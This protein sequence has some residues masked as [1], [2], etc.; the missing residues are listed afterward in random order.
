MF[1]STI[2]WEAL[3]NTYAPSVIR[4][5]LTLDWIDGFGLVQPS[6]HFRPKSFRADVTEPELVQHALDAEAQNCMEEVPYNEVSSCANMFAVDKATDEAYPEGWRR[7]ITNLKNV[8]I[9]VNT[10]YLRLVTL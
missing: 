2:T 6:D 9:F 8:N 5:G 1:S 7:Q 10:T 4:D 3:H